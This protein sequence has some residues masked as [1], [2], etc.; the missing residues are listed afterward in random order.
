MR[1]S[2]GRCQ[3]QSTCYLTSCMPG[4]AISQRILILQ[5]TFFLCFYAIL[6]RLFPSRT[7][8]NQKWLGV[9]P[10]GGGE[11]DRIRRVRCAVT[12]A[13]RYVPRTTCLTRAL[14]ALDLL[15]RQRLP[16]ELR[17][18][19]AKGPGGRLEAH[20]WVEHD[21]AVVIG[22]SGDLSRFTA[23]QRIG[24]GTRKVGLFS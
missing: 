24:N 20:A 12:T 3:I 16:G 9:S 5:A 17:I 15:H 7:L 18:G 4:Q 8:T 21:G 13:S 1:D 22:D 23:L 19:V 6:L 2:P 10:R 14:T 11:G